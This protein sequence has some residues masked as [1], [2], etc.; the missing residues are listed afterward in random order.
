MNS[1]NMGSIILG[2]LRSVFWA[3][4]GVMILYFLCFA[5]FDLVNMFFFT[6]LG[7]SHLFV[8]LFICILGFFN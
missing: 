7:W 3:L 6:F 1:I 2:P 5:S 4:H 8:V